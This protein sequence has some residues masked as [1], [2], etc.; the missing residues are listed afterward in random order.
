MGADMCRSLSEKVQKNSYNFHLKGDLMDRSAHRG[1]FH[2]PSNQGSYKKFTK[3][4][5]KR[6]SWMV[7]WFVVIYTDPFNLP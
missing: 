7:S 4:Q 1:N 5:L 2:D 3:K 6:F